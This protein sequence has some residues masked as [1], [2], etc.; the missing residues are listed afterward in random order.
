[1]ENTFHGGKNM[2]NRR[3]TGENVKEKGR[4]WERKGKEKDKMVSKRVK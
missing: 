2:K 1:L 3:E 4:K